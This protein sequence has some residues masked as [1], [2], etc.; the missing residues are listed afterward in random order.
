M[1]LVLN[2]HSPDA[3][4]DSTSDGG[5]QLHFSKGVDEHGGKIHVRTHPRWCGIMMYVIRDTQ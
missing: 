1:R 3:P 5:V 2:V 4:Y